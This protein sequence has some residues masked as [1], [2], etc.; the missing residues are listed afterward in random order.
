M[1]DNNSAGTI[2]AMIGGALLGFAMTTLLAPQPGQ[3]LRQRLVRK[4]REHS[5]IL[6]DNEVDALIARLEADDDDFL[7]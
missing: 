1:A 6:S 7:A 3:T 2:G 4:L 5:I